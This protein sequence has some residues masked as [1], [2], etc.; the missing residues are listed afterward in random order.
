VIESNLNPGD[1]KTQAL[2]PEAEVY[3]TVIREMYGREGG[4]I[5]T[6]QSQTTSRTLPKT[7]LAETLRKVT[8][9]DPNSVGP[10]TTADF[11]EKNQEPHNL[12]QRFNTNI[13]YKLLSKEELDR[14]FSEGR[15]WP[16]YYAAY[17]AQGIIEFSRVGFNR[18][19][20]QALVYTGIQS[21]LK[22]GSGYYVLLSKEN[23]AWAIKHKFEVWAS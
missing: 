13:E 9:Q 4:S 17:H 11:L 21:G 14:I 16:E 19:M 22:T 2:G 8:E 12:S 23:N 3:S 5:L 6:I 1:E 7:D 10:E 18:G 20:D 15:G